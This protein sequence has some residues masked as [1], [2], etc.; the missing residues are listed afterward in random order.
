MSLAQ[1]TQAWLAVSTDAAAAGTGGYF[2][3]QRPRDTHPAARDATVAR[4]LLGYC[5][6]LTG[7]ELPR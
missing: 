6:E 5:A 4:Q 1:V 2:Y 3:H 7:V